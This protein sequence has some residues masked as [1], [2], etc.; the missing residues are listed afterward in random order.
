MRHGGRHDNLVSSLCLTQC[1][2]PPPPFEKILAMSQVL[3]PVRMSKKKHVYHET[4]GNVRLSD[5]T[6]CYVVFPKN[7]LLQQDVLYFYFSAFQYVMTISI[8]CG[9]G[10]LL[11]CHFKLA[12]KKPRLV[13]FYSHESWSMFSCQNILEQNRCYVPKYSRNIASLFGVFD[14]S[15]WF[16]V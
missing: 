15:K 13:S 6:R 11:A 5:R 3:P 16:F 1:E 14:I 10:R 9:R 8:N 7:R 12:P 2:H 4:V